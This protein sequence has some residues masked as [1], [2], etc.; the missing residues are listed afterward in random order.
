MTDRTDTRRITLGDVPIGGGSPVTVQSMT[1]T[2][3]SDVAST[4]AQI[5][6]LEEAGC[7]I[8]R[9][10]VPDRASA[11]A[12]PA[13]I[14]GTSMPVVADIH[15]DYR[16][17]LLAME[18][19]APGVRI[20]PGTLGSREQVAAIAKEAAA[21][22][23]VVRVGVNSG[24]LER[25]L[26][27]G[28]ARAEAGALARSA[29]EGVALLEEH[30]VDRIKISVKA[31]DV[32]RTMAAYREV[33][34]RSPWP[35]HL[36]ITEAGTLWSGALKSAVGI[37]AMLAMGIGDTIRVSLT[38]PPLEEVRVARKILQAL[39]LGGEGPEVISC[40]TCARAEI[41]VVDLALKVEK[42]L[43]GLRTPLRVAVMGCSVNGP[44]E[45]READVGIAGGREG[46]LLFVRG[47]MVGRV[48]PGDMLEGLLAEVERLTEESGKGEAP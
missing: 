13:I 4:L 35:L 2:D 10:A 24:S 18:A 25:R 47:E 39:E 41:D 32:P 40:P 45:A 21:R 27:D 1:N 11:L 14:G 38:A 42:A 19:G 23:V 43:E 6:E 16:L 8:V 30:G 36:G 37:G 48:P 29:L 26:H 46:G 20:N 7:D 44:G 31:S 9:V 12:L 34:E 28:T 33:S 17:A 15:F 5:A 22:G 3:T